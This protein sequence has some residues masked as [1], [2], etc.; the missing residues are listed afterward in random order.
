MICFPDD[1]IYVHVFV[2]I[3]IITLIRFYILALFI[4]TRSLHSIHQIEKVLP[5]ELTPETTFAEVL[6]GNSRKIELGDLS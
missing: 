1:Q 3:V 6:E 4:I 5:F 2:F